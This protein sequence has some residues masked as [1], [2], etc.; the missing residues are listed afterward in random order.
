MAPLSH[1]FHALIFRLTGVG[2]MH[3]V[4]V[5]FLIYLAI[6]ALIYRGVRL[7]WGRTAAFASSLAFVVIFS[8]NQLLGTGN[9]NFLSPYAH[10][11]THGFLLVLVLIHL[12]ASWLENPRRRKIVSAGLCCGLCALL[13][14]EVLFAAGM[15]TAG[16]L[17]IAVLTVKDLR[18]FQPWLSIAGPFFLAGWLPPLVATLVL[19]HDGGFPLAT[20]FTWANLAWTGLFVYKNIV[21]DPLQLQ[22][23]GLADIPTNLASIL[24]Y[25]GV[26]VAGVFLLAAICQRMKP[27]KGM[28][29]LGLLLPGVAGLA[30]YWLPWTEWG[31]TFPAWLCTI[32]IIILRENR[33][34]DRQTGPTAVHSASVRWLF[35]LAAVAF[36]ARMSFNPRIYH[37]GY[38][39]AALSGVVIVATG[40]RTLPDLFTLRSSNRILYL[41]SLGIFFA[42]GLWTIEEQS[43]QVLSLKTQRIGEGVDQFYGFTPSVDPTSALLEAARKMLSGKTDCRNLLVVPE[44]VT[45]N[46][47]LRK[48]VP[49]SAYNFNPYWLQ[50][51]DQILDGLQ[52]HPPDY[53]VLIT[54]D[55]REYGMNYFGDSP[56]HGAKIMAW[57]RG[58]YQPIWQAGGNPLD[59]SQRGVVIL[60]K[61]E[62]APSR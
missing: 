7:G 55:M 43:R 62:K 15:V 24:I 14:V 48:P 57:I 56:E 25:G 33:P 30:S 26:S 28:A 60:Q 11:T 42:V 5:N 38:C 58:N 19:W 2:Y 13:K 16:A 17:L 50:W 40:F 23:M 3:L 53:V 41:A 61:A 31:T 9:Y 8:F 22:M 39:Q 36:L 45:L 6:L 59:M 52:K 21:S 18:R 4:W 29:L 51:R 1:Y 44:G 34:A 47:L 27:L 37:Y 32:L 20:A 46:Y 10:E 54:R 35:V 12:W 49:I